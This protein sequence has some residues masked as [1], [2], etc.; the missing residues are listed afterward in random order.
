MLRFRY[1]IGVERD[2][3]AVVL[4][5]KDGESCDEI[6]DAAE[7]EGVQIIIVM[8]DEAAD[9]VAEHGAAPDGRRK[10]AEGEALPVV[11]R[12]SRDHRL[13][14][15]SRSRAGGCGEPQENQHGGSRDIAHARVDESRHERAAQQHGLDAETVGQEAPDGHEDRVGHRA[16][17]VE[18]GDVEGEVMLVRH[19]QFVLQEQRD[20][21]DHGAESGHDEKLREPQHDEIEF[22]G[23]LFIFRFGHGKYRWEGVRESLFINDE[24]NIKYT[25]PSKKGKW[26]N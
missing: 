23:G 4:R 6:E 3:C 24:Q 19:H 9:D 14:G 16:E 10:K 20:E 11:R 15:G 2:A 7:P 26:L 8:D 18:E 17:E 22:P 1:R 5:E 13:G 25:F 12:G 21:G